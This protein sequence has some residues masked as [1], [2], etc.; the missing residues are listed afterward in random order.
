MKTAVIGAGS[1]GTA[2]A[3][4][5]VDAGHEV[6][7]WAREPEIEEKINRDHYNPTY[8][9]DIRLSNKITAYSSL[10]DCC[11]NTQLIIMATPS[12]AMREMAQQLAECID[13]ETVV[14]S[15]AKGIELDGFN[16]MSE[17]LS[18]VLHN[19]VHPE[20]IGVLSGPSHA[21]EVALRKP[22]AVVCSSK[23]RETAAFIQRNVMTTSLRIYI[24]MDITGVEIAGSVKNIM[25]IATG[26]IAGADYG[27]NAA[28]GLI[29]RSLAEIKRLGI[30]M[31]A[32]D[33]TFNGLA[34]IGDLVVTCTSR[35]SRNRYVGYQIGKGQTLDQ[36]IEGMDMVA[37]GVK[38]TRSVYEW[39]QSLN[40]EMP[41]TESVY[42]VLFENVKPQEAAHGLMT[43]QPKEE[44]QSV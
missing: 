28:A 19:V 21:E 15:V 31:G 32:N 12:H 35:H 30:K 39:A 3:T 42:Q 14:V 29:T 16:T 17:V 25:A 7:L 41:I 22:T 34:G 9:R 5:L 26:I 18:D 4:V 23:S 6:A 43:R 44:S 24:N 8:L 36:I 10:K 38:T 37:E 27:D 1:W 13:P 2:L 11:C 33:E 20:Q 40:I